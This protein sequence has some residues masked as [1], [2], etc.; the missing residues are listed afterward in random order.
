MRRKDLTVWAALLLAVALAFVFAAGC[1]GDEE[2]TSAATSPSPSA[3]ADLTP[4]E[5]VDQSTAAMNGLTSAAFTADVKLGLEGDASKMSDPT[6]QQLLSKPITLHM[7]GASSTKPQAADM[8]VTV[9]LMGQNLQ[10]TVLNEGKKAWVEYEDTWYAIPQED[11]K[12]LQSSGSG[13]LPTE[14]LS[15]L[16]LDPKAWTVDWELLGTETYDGAEV[17][18]LKAAPDP[19]QIADDVMKALNDPE[20]YKQ[21]GDPEAAEQLKAMK[22]Q[23]AKQLKEMQKALE[24]VEVQLWVDVES[25]YLRQGTVAI[26]MNTEGMEGAEGLTAMNVDIAFTMDDFDEP[27]EVEAPAKA[28]DFDTLMNQLVGGMMGTSF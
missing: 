14:Q 2:K 13:A 18:H 8:D 6:A 5:I 27:V 17:Y 21:L 28:K 15:E 7:E 26:G 9:S 12:A 19:K 23:N 16:G 25:M 20:L 3:A 4:Q 1:G 22:A 10:M 11:T 24:N